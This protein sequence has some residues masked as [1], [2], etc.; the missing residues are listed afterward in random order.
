MAHMW[1][2][3]AAGAWAV[4]ALDG[5]AFVLHA[6]RVAPLAADAAAAGAPILLHHDARDDGAEREVWAVLGDV[7]VNG[8]GAA[9]RIQALRDRD[10]LRLPGTR[11]AFFSTERLACVE[12]MPAAERP[13]AC[14][15]CTQ[16]IA[17]GSPAVRCP[18]CGVHYH[19]DPAARLPCWTYHAT[20]ALCPQPTALDGGYRWTPEE[21]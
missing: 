21:A 2:Q 14:P 15:R 11:P 19:Q 12:P 8:V 5:E 10:E 6:S 9:T 3:D 18:A 16:A 7:L 17:A 20:C 13:V 1:F 4:V